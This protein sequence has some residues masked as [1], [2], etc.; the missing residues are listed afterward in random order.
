MHLSFYSFG[1][2]YDLL[3]N[4]TAAVLKVRDYMTRNEDS[5]PLIC[6]LNDKQKEIIYKAF[7]EKDGYDCYF[8]DFTLV[9]K[10][11]LKE[12]AR[13]RFTHDEMTVTLGEISI[14]KKHNSCENFNLFY[15]KKYYPYFDG[16]YI[17]YTSYN[18]KR[19]KSDVIFNYDNGIHIYFNGTLCLCYCCCELEKIGDLYYIQ[20]NNYFDNYFV[21]LLPPE[22]YYI[23][24]EDQ[25]FKIFE[26][27]LYIKYNGEHIKDKICIGPSLF[28]EIGSSIHIN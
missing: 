14:I 6:P 7:N 17:D 3:I 20:E 21:L 9:V 15:E 22:Y 12:V 25:N 11:K 26:G 2:R 24:L 18:I 19:C 16:E 28:L 4:D 8:Q 13:F 1:T 10:N 5:R 27:K 23:A